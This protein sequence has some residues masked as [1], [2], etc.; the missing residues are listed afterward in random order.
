MKHHVR[1]ELEKLALAQYESL[2][3]TV[4]AAVADLVHHRFHS[5]LGRDTVQDLVVWSVRDALREER[6][7]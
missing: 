4:S 5:L 2:F 3:L 1:G 6:R 7:R